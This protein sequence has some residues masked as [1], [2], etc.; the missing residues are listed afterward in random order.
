MENSNI[1]RDEAYKYVKSCYNAIRV[2][3]YIGV[4]QKDKVELEDLIKYF[5]LAVDRVHSYK[6]L[7]TNLLVKEKKQ[8]VIVLLRKYFHDLFPLNNN[9]EIVINTYQM[10]GRKE[11]TTLKR[12]IITYL[13]ILT[14]K[15]QQSKVTETFSG[16]KLDLQNM[17]I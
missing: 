16:E 5:M 13:E 4:P 2:I 15:F 10:I 3:K 12:S 14:S 11:F 17:L 6:Y 7:N 1:E 8:K 9:T